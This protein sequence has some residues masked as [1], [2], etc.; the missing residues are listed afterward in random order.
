[1][2]K[3]L[4][5]LLAIAFAACS[6]DSLDNMEDYQPQEEYATVFDSLKA[7]LAKNSD[8]LPILNLTVDSAS[9]NSSDYIAAK[10]EI[11]DRERR[12]NS[13]FA[14]DMNGWPIFPLPTP[15][16]RSGKG[17]GRGNGRYDILNCNKDI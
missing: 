12:T 2:K 17:V 14:K 10:L 15:L 5:A 1:M 16:E 9:V 4:F 11:A 13:T 3:L 7:S 6:K 8:A